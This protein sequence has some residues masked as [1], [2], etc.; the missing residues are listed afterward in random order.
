MRLSAKCDAKCADHQ[1]R[2]R[3]L[4]SYH[5]CAIAVTATHGCEAAAKKKLLYLAPGAKLRS[6][7]H[8]R[9]TNGRQAP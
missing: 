2:A 7:N 8:K 6:S 4:H 3:S 5:S 1:R 9:A